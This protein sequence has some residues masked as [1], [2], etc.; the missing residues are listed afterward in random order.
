MTTAATA[1]H[2]LDRLQAERHLAIAT[3]MDR[4]A[5]YM[6]DLEADLHASEAAYVG[7]A[8]TEIAILRGEL[9]GRL[10]G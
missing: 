9:G 10:H 1:R 7:L 8:V 2:H 5:T 3:G 4:N 6:D